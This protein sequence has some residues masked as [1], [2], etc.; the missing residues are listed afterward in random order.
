MECEAGIDRGSTQQ[1]NQST[2]D[3]YFSNKVRANVACPRY[4]AFLAIHTTIL[5]LEIVAWGYRRLS[6]LAAAPRGLVQFAVNF[7]VSGLSRRFLFPHV[8]TAVA[9]L[10]QVPSLR[11]MRRYLAFSSGVLYAR[12]EHCLL[13]VIYPCILTLTAPAQY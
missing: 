9:W 2:S 11:I 13:R 4:G 12:A 7:T 5:Y 1:I 8:G 6:W 10:L 3:Y